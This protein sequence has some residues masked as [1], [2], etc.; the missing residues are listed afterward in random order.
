MSTEVKLTEVEAAVEDFAKL[1]ASSLRSPILKKP[2]DMG[3]EYEDVWFPSQDGVILEGWFIP[4]KGSNKLI[5]ANHPLPCNRY[6]YPGHIPGYGQF[7]GFEVNFIRDYKHLHDAGY[8]VL[9]YDMRNHG[10]SGVGSGGTVGI[11][12]LEYRDVIGSLRYARSRPDTAKM[13]TALLSRCLGANSTIIAMSRHPDEFKDIKAMVAVQPVSSRPLVETL[14]RQTGHD[15]KEAAD[16]FDRSIFNK[17]GFRLD[18]LGPIPYCKDVT[19]PTLVV[20][21]HHDTMTVPEDVQTI[22]DQ[23]G[24]KEKELF[25]I[26]GTERRFDG[27][28]YLGE[29]NPDLMLNWYKKYL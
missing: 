7:G 13:T 12:Q 1:F 9:C 25:W 8:N 6:G 19:V 26:E 29:K 5:I 22:Y 2:S 14:G 15:P 18:E 4:A 27:Y 20:Q 3:M 28:N 17:T 24:S 23:L 21:V 16:A 10:R 11:G